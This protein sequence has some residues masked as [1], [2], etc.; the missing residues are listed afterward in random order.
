[1]V[2]GY[3]R[4]MTIQAELL[5]IKKKVIAEQEEMLEK[6]DKVIA[7][8]AETLKEQETRAVKATSVLQCCA[9]FRSAILKLIE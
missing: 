6:K 5:E 4:M 1:M 8:Q 2:N 7:E 9:D 3:D